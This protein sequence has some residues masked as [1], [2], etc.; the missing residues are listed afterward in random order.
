[1]SIAESI[2]KADAVIVAER[3][4]E[5]EG[6]AKGDLSALPPFIDIDVLDILKGNVPEHKIRV[7][8]FSG[9]CPY[10]IYFQ[11]GTKAVVI[12]AHR[13]SYYDAVA[14]HCSV[15]VLPYDGEKVVAEGKGMSLRDFA[16]KYL[17]AAF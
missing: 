14:G 2:E 6:E 5:S 17:K 3:T 16:Q 7:K 15:R 4:T 8:S 13:Q 12:L 1:M 10:G 11:K 9:M